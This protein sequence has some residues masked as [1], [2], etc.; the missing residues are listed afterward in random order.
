MKKRE[1]RFKLKNEIPICETHKRDD[2]TM[3]SKE[4]LGPCVVKKEMEIQKLD[5]YTLKE[6]EIHGLV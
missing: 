5:F 4:V 1:T 3:N 2:W 6:I